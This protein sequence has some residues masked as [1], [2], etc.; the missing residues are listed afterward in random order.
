MKKFPSLKKISLLLVIVSC[1]YKASIAQLV[2]TPGVHVTSNGSS[3]QIVFENISLVNNGV[4][5]HTEGTI[6]FSGSIATTISGV[7]FLNFHNLELNKPSATLT[8]SQNMV[9]SSQLLFS[10]GLLNL[11]GYNIDLGATGALVNESETNRAAGHNGGLITTTQNL[12]APNAANPG[13]LGAII[14]SSQN[15]GAV[16]IEKRPSV[17]SGCR[18]WTG[19]SPPL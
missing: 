2:I 14:S 13:N 6:K 15:L 10:A 7:G 19:H 17:A 18:R 16:V 1:V 4:I 11:N 9:V 3:T 12:N 8:L 5:N